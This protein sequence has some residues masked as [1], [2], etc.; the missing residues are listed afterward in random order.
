MGDLLI[1]PILSSSGAVHTSLSLGSN[2]K[3]IVLNQEPPNSPP[4]PQS[5]P[6]LSASMAEPSLEAVPCPGAPAGAARR[7]MGMWKKGKFRHYVDY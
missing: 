7:N 1:V 4:R 5:I 3:E 6:T 2:S